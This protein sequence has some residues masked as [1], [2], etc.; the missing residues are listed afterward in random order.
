MMTSRQRIEAAFDHREPD[1]TPIYEY[2]LLSPVADAILDRPL[3]D[4][5]YFDQLVKEVGFEHALRRRATDLVEIAARLGHDMMY[6]YM[7]SPPSDSSLVQVEESLSADDPVEEVAR[8]VTRAEQA[9]DAALPESSFLIYPFIREAMVRCEID[10]PILAPAYG[11]GVWTDVALM[12]TMILDEDLARRHFTL[13]TRNIL[14][15]V[16]KYLEYDIDLFGVGG[17]FAGN[18][19]PL[20]SPGAYRRFI[21]PE[22]RKIA[23]RIHTAGKRAV[24]TSDGNLWPVIDDF[25]LGCGVDGYLEIDYHAGMDLGELKKRFGSRVTLVGNLDCGNILSF[26]TPAQV[27]QHTRECLVKGW[28]GGGHILCCSNAITESVPVENYLAIQ[29]AYKKYFSL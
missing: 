8:R 4:G 26:G 10:L 7:V 23:D 5:A 6:V 3:A 13:A 20:I 14:H 24:N 21:V 2:I 28:G 29:T 17:D 18:R 27:E 15:K 1:R 22:I 12:Q 19:G 11:H 9:D 16:E 25:L